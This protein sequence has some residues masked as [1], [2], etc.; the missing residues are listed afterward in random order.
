MKK[1]FFVALFILL[2]G[3]LSHAQPVARFV[4]VDHD[5]GNVAE[6]DKIELTRALVLY[7]VKFIEM[8]SP[9]VS[10]HLAANSQIP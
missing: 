2:T 10:P 7:G 4:Q 9:V 8:F 3:S 1:I 6:R 5:F